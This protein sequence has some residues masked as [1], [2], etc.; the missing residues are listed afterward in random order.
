[1]ERPH[2]DHTTP[3]SLPSGVS[4]SHFVPTKLGGTEPPRPRFHPFQ[5]SANLRRRPSAR[6]VP[7]G[8]FL[9]LLPIILRMNSSPV[10]E[11]QYFVLSPPGTDHERSGTERA[12]GTSGRN[13]DLHRGLVTTHAH[14]PESSRAPIPWTRPQ[15]R[16]GRF[17][18]VQA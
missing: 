13:T 6:Q 2:N 1:M 5:S 16:A 10:S 11:S 8:Q 7:K 3:C 4:L 14:P 9:T 15:F 17:R 18:A 12:E